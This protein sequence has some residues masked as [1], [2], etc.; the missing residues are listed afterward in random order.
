[1][2]SQNVWESDIELEKVSVSLPNI[3]VEEDA[4]K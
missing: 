1:M 2:R 3:S 4:D